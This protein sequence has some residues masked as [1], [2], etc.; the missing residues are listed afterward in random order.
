MRCAELETPLH[1]GGILIASWDVVCG[2]SAEFLV[3]L[4]Q[5]QKGNTHFRYSAWGSHLRT[6]FSYLYFLLLFCRGWHY[7]QTKTLKC[8][9]VAV[10]MSGEILNSIFNVFNN[11]NLASLTYKFNSTLNTR[12]SFSAGKLKKNWK[13]W[14]GKS[15]RIRLS[16]FRDCVSYFMQASSTTVFIQ[17]VGKVTT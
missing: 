7:L 8:W 12:Y 2:S 13:Q 4:I 14:E 3:L 5:N 16:H 11:L 1:M 10:C 6:F 17:L 9:Y 15:Q